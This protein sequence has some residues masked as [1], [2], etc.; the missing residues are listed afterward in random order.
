MDEARA[1]DDHRPDL[2]ALTVAQLVEVDVCPELV[3]RDREVGALGL[4]GEDRAEMGVAPERVDVQLV[5]P[6]VE[7]REVRQ[8]LNVVPVG[9][10]DEEVGGAAP[11]AELPGRQVLA[12]PPDPGAGVDDDGIHPLGVDLDARGVTAI[13]V[14]LRTGYRYRSADTPESGLH[15]SMQANTL[16]TARS[17]PAGSYGWSAAPIR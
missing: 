8:P 10:A 9:V 7:R 3:E 15:P 1:A 17:I 16:K 14:G 4:R 2:E 5:A 6:G 11:L 12:Q 13:A